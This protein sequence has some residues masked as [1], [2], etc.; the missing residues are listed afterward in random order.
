[1]KKT[2]TKNAKFLKILQWHFHCLET[3]R[4]ATASFCKTV[5]VKVVMPGS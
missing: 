5:T 3:L 1:M 2:K 4:N